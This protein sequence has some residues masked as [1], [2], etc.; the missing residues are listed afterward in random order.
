MVVSTMRETRVVLIAPHAKLFKGGIAQFA[1]RLAEELTKRTELTFVTWNRLY[2]P[3][4][5]KRDFVAPGAESFEEPKGVYRSLSYINPLSW[6]KT[7]RLVWREKPTL[8]L[9]SWV[10]PVHAPVLFCLLG[11]LR[12]RSSA[13][14]AFVCHN[15]LPHESF[16]GAQFLSRLVLGL[17]D[18]VIIHSECERK[19]LHRLLPKARCKTL[20]IPTFDMFS[21]ARPSQRGN[22]QE[23]CVL[24]FGV[25]RPYKGL[26]VLLRAVAELHHSGVKIRLL[27]AG[28]FLEPSE[29]FERECS[30]KNPLLLISELEIESIVETTIS[31]IKDEQVGEL[32]SKA[33]VAVF[34][35]RSATQSAVVMLAYAY[36]V[37]VIATGVGG[38]REVVKEG[39]SGYVCEPEDPRAL[40][41]AILRY[42]NKP[43]SS[44]AVQEYAKSFSWQSY[45]DQILSTSSEEPEQVMSTES[46][47]VVG[48]GE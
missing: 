33:D 28:E 44:D 38:L 11:L 25:I 39:V 36:G 37:P 27:I 12:L 29:Q 40:S 20:F 32:F 46:T 6:L 26:D 47:K 10:H 45:V 7:A 31:Y 23:I 16:R 8:L 18:E 42:I 9:V 15:V 17:A 30:L 24:F 2:P 13:K 22:K 48:L 14:V 3:F 21:A 43:I 19:S 4:L 34:P 35:Y 41:R 5:S 1:T